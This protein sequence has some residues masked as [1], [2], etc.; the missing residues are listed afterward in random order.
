MKSELKQ[1]ADNSTH[2][3]AEERTQLLRLL[4]Y[5]RGLFGG[6]LGYWATEPVYLELNPYSKTF[7]SIYY[8]VPRINKETSHK[9]L[10]RLVEIGVLNPVQW[11]QYSTPIFIIPKKEGNVRFITDYRRINQQLTK[12][13]YPL[14]KIGKTM[15]K[16]EGL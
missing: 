4:E 14:T 1:V 13:P 10:N 9:D 12:N 16:L 11:S 3:N 5:F 7:N 8:T 6:N 2:L 15:Q